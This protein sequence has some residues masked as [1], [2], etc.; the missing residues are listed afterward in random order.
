VPLSECVPV[1][2][3]TKYS[4]LAPTG[5][6]EVVP[7]GSATKE[8]EALLQRIAILHEGEVITFGVRCPFP[9][10]G[11]FNT[12]SFGI[13]SKKGFDNTESKEASA[14]IPRL[15]ALRRAGG[16]HE[17]LHNFRLI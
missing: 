13:V 10:A 3:K 7:T 12:H 9:L 5:V 4:R 15:V 11:T 8:E 6:G 16:G 17:V 2:E 14:S 1:I